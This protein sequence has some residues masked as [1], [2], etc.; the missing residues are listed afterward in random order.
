[1]ANTHLHDYHNLI[2]RKSVSFEACGLNKW[3]DLPPSLFDHQRHGVEFAL[4]AGCSAMFYDTGLGKTAMALAWGDQIVRATN[5]PVLM[6]APLA[7]GPQHSREAAR[8]GI[9][10]KVIRDGAEVG[11]PQIYIINYDRLDKIDAAKFGGVILDESS[12]L[13]SFTGATTRALIGTFAGTPYRLACTATP[14][15]NDHMELG[16]HS[17]FLGVMDSNE[18]LARW[19]IADQQNMGK[20][21]V[22][23]A[24]ANPF[25]QWVASWARCVSRPSDLGFSDAGFILPE[26]VTHRH[27]IIADITIAAG[28]EKD[29]QSR[30]FRIPEM[31]ATSIHREKRIT[32]ES[33]A[34]RIADCIASERG[35]SWVVWVDTNDESDAM[36]SLLPAGEFVEVRGSQSADEK[37]EK[38]T[39]FSEGR[40]RIII[41]KS[42]I[43]GFGLNWQHC[44]R[45]A[46]VGLSF[47][48]ESYY[49]AVRRSWRF[50]QKRPV[51]VHIA[52][53]DT[54][55]SIYDTVTRKAGDHEK[56]KTQMS[57]AMARAAGI[58]KV[59][60]SYQPTNKGA[61][62][63]WMAS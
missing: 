61:L 27:E 7:V 33:R 60:E 52:C 10:A 50:G 13:K 54:E 19:F 21:R 9:D 49:Q 30:L 57:A 6:L 55:R 16:Q 44:A 17:Q 63:A 11:T 53:A 47:S 48:Y 4:R 32:L 2:A 39:A 14:A 59:Y 34:N 31:S 58:S 51:H 56:M 45:Q 22:K 37:E 42:S 46:F 20:Y 25:W 3:G 26:L 12:I 62:P 1:M 5:K 18:M 38:I 8:L 24:G 36:M 35:E 23:K 43:T 40:A 28:S 29:G 41:S 15:P